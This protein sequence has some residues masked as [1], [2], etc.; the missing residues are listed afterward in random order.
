MENNE[1]DNTAELFR[2]SQQP[3]QHPHEVDG[4]RRQEALQLRLDDSDIARVPH[5]SIP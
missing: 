2:H 1:S 4:R 3:F 5:N